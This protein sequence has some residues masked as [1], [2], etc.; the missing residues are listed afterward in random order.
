MNIMLD[1]KI[2]NGKR[3]FSLAKFIDE[4]DNGKRI[5]YIGK[6]FVVLSIMEY[7]KL[8]RAANSAGH[9]KTVQV[10]RSMQKLKSKIQSIMLVLKTNI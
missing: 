2:R 4:V 5:I 8:V 9:Y 1:D 3:I 6:E 7:K 10:K